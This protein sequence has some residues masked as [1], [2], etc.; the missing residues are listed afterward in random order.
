M[1]SGRAPV[2]RQDVVA[3]RLGP[4]QILQLP[5]L[6]GLCRGEVVGLREILVDVVQLPLRLVESKPLRSGCQGT[7]ESEEAIQPFW[8]MPRL[9]PISKYWVLRRLG[10]LASSKV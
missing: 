3:R 2:E 5:Q 7:K 8:Y 1:R 9:T 10:A 6:V 4:P